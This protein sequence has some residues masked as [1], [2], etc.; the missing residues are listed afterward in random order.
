MAGR[1]NGMTGV[2][3]RI[4]QYVGI[5]KRCHIKHGK[6]KQSGNSGCD[7]ALGKRQRQ[8]CRIGFCCEH[9]NLRVGSR[10]DPGQMETPSRSNWQV[11]WLTALTDFAPS[12]TL[13]IQLSGSVVSANSLPQY[14]RGVGQVQDALFGSVSPCSLLIP[15]PLAKI[16]NHL[17]IHA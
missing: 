3:S 1:Y 9:D 14:S 15:W 13:G 16:G 12:Q 4:V 5:G 8:C 10:T 7:E 2:M 11:S 6:T 17:V